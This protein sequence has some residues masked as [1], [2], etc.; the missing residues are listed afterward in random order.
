M[1]QEVVMELGMDKTG[2]QGTTGKTM[3]TK[4]NKG[5]F[6]LELNKVEWVQV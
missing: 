3:K 4:R 6:A 5:W 1:S 2:N